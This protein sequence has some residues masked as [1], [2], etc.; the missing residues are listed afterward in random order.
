MSRIT[1]MT[2]TKKKM[3]PAML[4]KTQKAIKTPITATAAMAT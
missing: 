2:L 1:A 3:I 4:L